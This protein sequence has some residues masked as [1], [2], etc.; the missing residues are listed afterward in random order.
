MLGHASGV[1]ARSRVGCRCVSLLAS[2]GRARATTSPRQTRRRARPVTPQVG[3]RR[4]SALTRCRS[5]PRIRRTTARSHIAAYG[6]NCCFENGRPPL[7]IW[8]EVSPL[9][10]LELCELLGALKVMNLPSLST[11]RISPRSLILT[12]PGRAVATTRFRRGNSERPGT[13]GEDAMRAILIRRASPDDYNG[14]W[15]GFGSKRRVQITSTPHADPI[16]LY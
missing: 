13:P 9:D 12:V 2:S 6:S 15:S 10:F 7:S 3:Q 11:Q 8:V 5:R 4:R 16:R 1:G 14:G